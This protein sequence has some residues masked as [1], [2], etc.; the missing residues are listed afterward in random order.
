MTQATLQPLES[1]K[2]KETD[3]LLGPSERNKVLPTPLSQSSVTGM[4]ILTVGKK[5]ALFK[6]LS[7]R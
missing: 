5:G 6:S 1:G 4:E 2:I 3:S 7:L